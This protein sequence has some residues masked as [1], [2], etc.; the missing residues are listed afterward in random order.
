M[1]L[2]NASYINQ[3]DASN[4]PSTD[5]I[6]QADDHIRMLKAALKATFP[7][8]TGPV[9][10]TQDVLNAPFRFPIGIV[11]IWY[12]AAGDVPGGWA[13]CNGQTVARSDGQGNITLPNLVDRTVIGAGGALAGVGVPIGSIASSATSTAAGGHLHTTPTGGSHSHTGS[14]AGHALTESQL[15]S[16]RHLNGVVSGRDEVF[17]HGGAPA[18]PT[19]GR[20]LGGSDSNG[21]RE[22][23][24]T[25]VGGNQ[26]HN[27]GLSIDPGGEHTHTTTSVG[28]HAHNVTVSTVQP[29]MG[30]H[31]IMKI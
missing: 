5:L 3:L 14:V 2:E 27:H 30:L 9:S 28:D 23:Y 18:S 10:V 6:A 15:P 24:T 26:A 22:G 7:N 31:Y 12:G 21:T 11:S 17:N 19:M 8:I 4:P 29:C 20:S 25:S 16:H 13:I 1:P